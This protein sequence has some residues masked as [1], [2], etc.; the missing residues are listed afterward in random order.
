MLIHE[1]E[2]NSLF[3]E[4]RPYEVLDAVGLLGG[5]FI[6][7]NNIPV[8]DE[9][10]PLFEHRFNQRAR[11]I[12]KE[13]G[14]VAIRVL[15]P[16]NKVDCIS[17]ED[18]DELE[19][20]LRKLNPEAKIIRTTYGKVALHD[21]LNT[22]LFDFEKASQSAGWI[23]ELNE[24]HTPETEEYGI[25]SFVYR[26]RRPFHPE[27]LMHWPV[28]VVRAKGFFWLASRN[29]MCG[30]LS[31]AG[32]SIIMQGAGEWIATYPLH[33]REHMLQEDPE[34]RAKWDDTYGDR[35]TELVFIGIDM[36]EHAI[37]SSLDACL[38]TD[39]EMNKDWSTFVDPLP[40]FVSFS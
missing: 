12:E 25:S 34:L 16:L 31:Q 26:R 29:N 15:R 19:A 8:T 4:P 17:K 37:S 5:E 11:L 33:E 24:E 6:V 10:R 32:P 20:L 14:F 36:D 9:G 23:K 2:G 7:C 1:T 39:E 3:H 38:L 27:R 30:L 18:A 13:P 40:P 35:M 28:E 21:I 22:R